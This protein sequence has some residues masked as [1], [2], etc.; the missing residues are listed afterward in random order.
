MNIV[1]IMRPQ[2]SNDF[3]FDAGLLELVLSAPD[4]FQRHDLK[5]K[6]SEI[7]EFESEQPIVVGRAFYEREVIALEETNFRSGR[8]FYFDENPVDE[9]T[10]SL[11]FVV[12]QFD[13]SRT[14]ARW[15]YVF[16]DNSV[17]ARERNRLGIYTDSDTQLPPRSVVKPLVD[18]D[19]DATYIREYFLALDAFGT[20]AAVVFTARYNNVLLPAFYGYYEEKPNRPAANQTE[21]DLA[22]DALQIRKFLSDLMHKDGEFDIEV[23]HVPIL[24][25]VGF[26]IKALRPNN[27]DLQTLTRR[28][29][30]DLRANPKKFLTQLHKSHSL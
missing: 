23:K 6:R 10:R 3:W 22:L 5:Y 2:K 14:I 1:D 25:K 30:R 13:D 17:R 16:F 11:P 19:V 28:I 8:A 20:C 12:F 24:R 9:G 15:K 18:F 26:P 29:A 21:L 4:E 7:V 27:F